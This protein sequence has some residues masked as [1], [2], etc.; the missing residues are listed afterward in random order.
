MKV[1]QVNLSQTIPT[2]PNS[3]VPRPSHVF[4]RFTRKIEK[5][6]FSRETLKNMG[7][8]GYEATTN[9]LEA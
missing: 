2:L 7:R 8:L 1:Q 4:Q 3:L 6:G 5:S 9:S